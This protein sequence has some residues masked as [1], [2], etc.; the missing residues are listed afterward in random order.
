MEPAV[1][2]VTRLPHYGGDEGEP[3]HRRLYPSPGPKPREGHSARKIKIA[4]FIRILTR[5]KC[6]EVSTGKQKSGDQVAD[7]IAAP[8]A[9]MIMA[10][11]AAAPAP[12]KT[13]ST[14]YDYGPAI[15]FETGVEVTVT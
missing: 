13:G 8:E 11:D 1:D 12:A 10:E 14:N 4:F 2:N 7:K 3:A 15:G 5:K 9:I 6:L